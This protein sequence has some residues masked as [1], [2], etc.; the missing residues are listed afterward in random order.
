MKITIIYK[1]YTDDDFY[2]NNYERYDCI[3]CNNYDYFGIKEFESENE[4]QCISAA[5]IFLNKLNCDIDSL[6]Q[7]CVL[8]EL[9]EIICKIIKFISNL[10]PGARSECLSG[11]YEGTEIITII[12]K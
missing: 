2:L 11:N 4:K 10:K 9:N 3:E 12:Q 6:H 8:D 7:N 5:K 1:L